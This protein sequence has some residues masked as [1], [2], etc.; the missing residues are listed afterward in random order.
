MIAIIDYD[1]GNISAVENMLHR[2]GAESEITKDPEHIERA[3][4]II[5][6]GNGAFDACMSN[7]TASGLVPLL[8]RK[9]LEEATPL[10]GICVGAQMLGTA[11]EE[12]KHAG[13]GWLDM[14]VRR[15]PEIPGLRVPHMGWDQVC[16]VIAG[17][18]LLNGI[19]HESSFYFVHSYFMKPVNQSD[20]LLTA[21]Y[22]LEFAAGVTHANIAAVQFHPEKSHRFG[23][24]LLSQFAN[25]EG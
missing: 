24:Q 1:I 14:T 18:P 4:K 12:G 20:V 25:W 23:K 17:H 5:L 2:I 8:R 15:F 11:S 21:H 22:G 13:L 19:D 10:L 9:V 7:L 16:P 6:P 3:D